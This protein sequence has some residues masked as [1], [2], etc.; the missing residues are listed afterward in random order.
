M[1]FD[2]TRDTTEEPGGSLRFLVTLL[3]AV[4][5]L[6]VGLRLLQTPEVIDNTPSATLGPVG[7]NS[8]DYPS[9]A[10]ASLAPLTGDDRHWALVSF[11][12][13]VD[14][15]TAAAPFEGTTIRVGSLLVGTN[16]LRPLPQP[17]AGSTFED[18]FR[19]DIDQLMASAGRLDAMAALF[20]ELSEMAE[21]NLSDRGRVKISGLVIWATPD[22]L[23]AVRSQVATVQALPA[24]VHWGDIAVTAYVP[25]KTDDTST[26]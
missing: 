19:A 8:Q 18:V 9:M 11:G 4:G 20:P 5:L 7:V 25:G 6:G 24:S 14:E 2:R 21:Q 12:S 17:V 10:D 23:R 22:E 13:T 26:E 3:V 16:I 15:H 1:H